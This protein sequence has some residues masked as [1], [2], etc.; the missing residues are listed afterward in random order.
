M[1]AIHVDLLTDRLG[2]T[3]YNDRG[4]AEW[5]PHPSRLYSALVD[6]LHAEGQADPA[7]GRALDALA[8]LP[9]PRIF[10]A[11]A[12]ERRVLTVYV[13]VNDAEQVGGAVTLQK[14]EVAV[15]EAHQQLEDAMARVTSSEPAQARSSQKELQKAEKRLEKAQAKLRKTVHQATA[16]GS[17][18]GTPDGAHQLLPWNRTKQPRTFPV[19]IPEVP[20]VSYVWDADLDDGEE[21]RALRS[22]ARRV[23]RIGH[24][25]SFVALSVETLSESPSEGERLQW[26]P[27]DDG[28]EVFRVPTAGQR[29]ALD[30]AFALHQGNTPGRVLPTGFQRYALG[31]RI[32]AQAETTRARGTWIVYHFLGTRFPAASA[33]VAVAE[34]VKGAILHHASDPAPSELSGHLD[35]APMTGGHLAILPLPFVGHPH[36]DGL[37]RGFALSLP[38]ST[39]PDVVRALKR[40]LGTWERFPSAEATAPRTV[41]L[42]LAGGLALV[43][44]RV[45]DDNETLRSLRLNRWARPSHRWITAT[46]IALDGECHSFDAPSAWMRRKAVRGA[47]KLVRRAVLRALGDAA[48]GIRSDDIAVSLAFSPPLVGAPHNRDVPS[49]QRTGHPRPRRLV[50]AIIELPVSVRGPLVLGAGRHFG[51]GLC[52]P[53]LD[54]VHSG[55]GSR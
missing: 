14:D 26:R 9:P 28:D 27:D 8:A 47:I 42:N 17:R 22:V 5:P 35:G 38:R 16:I 1:L 51:L 29:Q 31:D 18:G 2:I 54:P 3:A 20:R 4:R 50:H 23:V 37:I 45:V 55:E 32:F 40:A 41:Q 48:H 33:A 11:P 12:H 6:A 43:A 24:S 19:I 34:A 39:N 46:P 52:V 30:S 13:P 53:S 36:A 25:S 49:F 21:L 44:E 15:A 10:A 7:E